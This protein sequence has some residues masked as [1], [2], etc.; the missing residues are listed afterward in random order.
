VEEGSVSGTKPPLRGFAI[1]KHLT[2]DLRQETLAILNTI[3]ATPGSMYEIV[4]LFSIRQ[5]D[6]E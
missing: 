2:A 3:I 1:L 4:R 5:Q 6:Q